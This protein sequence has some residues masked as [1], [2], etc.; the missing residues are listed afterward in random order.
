MDLPRAIELASANTLPNLLDDFDSLMSERSENEEAISTLTDAWQQAP[1]GKEPFSF[2]LVRRLADRNRAL[3][4]RIGIDRLR[5]VPDTSLA[6]SLSDDDLVAGL[7][8]L[9]HRSAKKIRRSA[10]ADLSDL[11]VAYVEAKVSGTVVG[12]DIETTDRYPD[13]G[14]IINLGFEFMRL[15]PTAKPQL[16]HVA[17]FGIPEIYAER[18]VPLASV[19]H[20]TYDELAD[21]TPFR[22]AADVHKA[23]LKVMRTYPYLAHNAAFE[24]SWFMLHMDGYAE[25]RKAGKIRIVDTRDICRRI[26]VDGRSVPHDQRPNAL[27]SWARRR[28]TLSPDEAERHLGLEDVDLMLRTVQAEFS[29]RTM[30]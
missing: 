20:I 3:C 26:D 5:K 6:R 18:G 27:E 17:Y 10:G 2:D 21:K 15:T 8:A 4:D 12:I 25:A 23:L 9:Q 28:G 14:Y 16:G 22:Q 7:A 30:F 11:A 24:D 13:R 29:L 1:K 19:H